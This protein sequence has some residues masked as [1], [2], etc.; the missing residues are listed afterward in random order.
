M[1]NDILE[2]ACYNVMGSNWVYFIQPVNHYPYQPPQL[3]PNPGQP[4]ALQPRL[5]STSLVLILD[6]L[7][8]IKN[9]NKNRFC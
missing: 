3:L 1:I 8:L 5:T 6:F 2:D 7:E 4:L 9:K